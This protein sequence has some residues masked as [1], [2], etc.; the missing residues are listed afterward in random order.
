MDDCIRAKIEDACCNFYS[1]ERILARLQM[2]ILHSAV[3]E[4]VES[5]VWA[6]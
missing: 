5:S 4:E 1:F 2:S 6:F 3:P